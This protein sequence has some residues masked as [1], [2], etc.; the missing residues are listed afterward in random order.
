MNPVRCDKGEHGIKGPSSHM[1][2]EIN[3]DGWSEKYAELER[4]CLPVLDFL[5][6]NIEI[7][8]AV[9]ITQNAMKS[10]LR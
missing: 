5:Q 3:E 10:R 8:S 2:F 4:L 6:R 1:L 9:E 7:A